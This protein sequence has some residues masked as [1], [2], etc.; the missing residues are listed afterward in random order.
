MMVVN[1]SYHDSQ[2][3]YYSTLTHKIQY[4]NQARPLPIVQYSLFMR[5][6][7]VGREGALHTLNHKVTIP[8]DEVFEF[9]EV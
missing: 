2:H 8:R 6:Q 3:K 4:V 9:V 1:S 5:V 7:F